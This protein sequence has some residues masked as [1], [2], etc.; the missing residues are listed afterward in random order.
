[1]HGNESVR[2]IWSA[3]CAATGTDPETRLDVFAFGD[4]PEMADRLSTLVLTGPKRATAGS[5]GDLQRDQEPIPQVGGHSVI[6]D[7][8]QTAVCVIR[9]TDLTIK[10]FSEVD[11][12]FAWDE[13]EGDR[14]LAGWRDAHRNFF[15]RTRAAHGLGFDDDELCVLERFAVVWPAPGQQADVPLS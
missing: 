2:A 6:V 8:S 1:M 7:G 4:S 14:T 12:A 15:T 11:A 3:Y 5:L 13:G 10:P 9:T